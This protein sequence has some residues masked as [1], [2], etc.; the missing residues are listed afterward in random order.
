MREKVEHPHGLRQQW[1]R[2]PGAPLILAV[3]LAFAGDAVAPSNSAAA[4]AATVADPRDTPVLTRLE[5]SQ[6]PETAPRESLKQR[7]RRYLTRPVARSARYLDHGVLGV[8]V[9]VGTPSIYR[10]EL[11]LGLFDHLTLGVTAHWLPSERV[12]RWTP[13]GSLAFFRGRLL[14]VG[15]SYHQLL[16]PPYDDGDTMTPPFGRRAHYLLG[17]I[18]FSQ[19]WFTAGVD[20]GWARGREN[21]PYITG[22]DLAAGRYYDVRDRLGAGLH[23][24]VG[25]RRIGLLA[26]LNF[27]YTAFE[28]ALDLRFGL[29]ELRSRGGWRQF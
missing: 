26:Q 20:I 1:W 22:D 23:M 29:F 18:S 3:A 10:V 16:Y 19:A 13:R 12:P 2:L 27:P 14:E 8:A 4:S 25:T 11:A 7:T 21:V 17:N 28:L 9:A 6:G 24:R 5:V 15:A